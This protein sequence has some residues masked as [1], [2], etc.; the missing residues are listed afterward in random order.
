MVLKKGKSC[1]QGLCLNTRVILCFFFEWAQTLVNPLDE[2]ACPT[3][4]CRTYD[5]IFYFL[6]LIHTFRNYLHYHIKCSK[7][8]INSRMRGKTN[9]FLKV[10]FISS[11]NFLNAIK[12]LN[13]ARP[14][15]SKAKKFG[16]WTLIACLFFFISSQKE[17]P[18][19]YENHSLLQRKNERK[20]CL[21]KNSTSF[22][23][24]NK[25]NDS[26]LTS[27]NYYL[28]IKQF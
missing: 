15:S 3:A 12:V 18:V 1:R 27:P 20:S 10:S 5:L 16:H 25:N 7:A 26:I 22:K 24:T 6:D 14:E 11:F 21:N 28:F 19:S 2:R 17:L 9:D 4:N 8:F 23:L 13:R